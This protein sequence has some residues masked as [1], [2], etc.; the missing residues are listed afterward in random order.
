M[1]PCGRCPGQTP[2][3]FL[4]SAGS[5]GYVFSAHVRGL[6]VLQAASTPLHI[7]IG[8][9]GGGEGSSPEEGTQPG[10]TGEGAPK[11]QGWD[12]I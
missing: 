11:K 10:R 2:D 7:I 1:A 3:V 4:P 8:D 9:L 5:L 12:G 6:A